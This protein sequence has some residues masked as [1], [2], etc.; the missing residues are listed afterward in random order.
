MSRATVAARTSRL[1]LSPLDSRAS[2]GVV[3][4]RILGAPPSFAGYGLPS[5]LGPEGGTLSLAHLGIA[6][7]SRPPR[8][9]RVAAARPP[10]GHDAARPSGSGSRRHRASESGNRRRDSGSRN[11]RRNRSLGGPPPS[12]ALGQPPLS[13]VPGWAPSLVHQGGASKDEP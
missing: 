2:C 4:A 7:A 5:S 10:W 11:R 1:S 13:H 9:P 8:G 12:R 3:A 6:T